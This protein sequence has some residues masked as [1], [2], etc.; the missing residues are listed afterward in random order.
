M[1]LLNNLLEVSDKIVFKI[2]DLK[3]L[4]GLLLEI[5]ATKITIEYEDVIKS[6]CCS[7]ICKKLLLFK[8][9]NEIIIN[10]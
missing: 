1:I 2:D 7:S 9:I 6:G 8:K 5:S 10:N 3:I 4:I